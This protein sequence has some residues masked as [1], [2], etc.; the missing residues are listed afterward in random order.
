MLCSTLR[1]ESR[2]PES[3]H[4]PE[5][6][7]EREGGGGREC[8]EPALP[9]QTC[10]HCFSETSSVLLKRCQ[11]RLAQALAAELLQA[12]CSR[13]GRERQQ[14]LHSSLLFFD[15][16]DTSANWFMLTSLSSFELQICQEC[17]QKSSERK[18]AWGEEGFICKEIIAF[19]KWR[20]SD[21]TQEAVLDI[22]WG[23]TLMSICGMD[24]LKMKAPIQ[25]SYIGLF[26]WFLF[27]GDGPHKTIS[28]GVFLLLFFSPRDWTFSL[29]LFSFQSSMT[30]FCYLRMYCGKHPRPLVRAIMLTVNT[31]F[32][33]LLQSN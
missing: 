11:W 16:P 9:S 23:K 5:S 27:V 6:P 1:A 18:T 19:K 14:L 28:L 15:L 8:K 17:A 12:Q 30:R 24:T 31:C 10:P 13:A 2:S 26:H 4:C 25:D 21:V 33:S 32:H 29:P 7:T 22:A 20:V 3:G